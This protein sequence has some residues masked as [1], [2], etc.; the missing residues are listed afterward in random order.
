MTVTDRSRP[1]SRATRG[2]EKRSGCA[3]TSPRLDPDGPVPLV[4][5]GEDCACQEVA[6]AALRS[7]GRGCN[8]VFTSFSLVSLAA[9][10]EAGFG[11]MVMPRG[12]RAAERLNRLEGRAAAAAARTLLRDIHSRGRQPRRDRGA[13]RRPHGRPVSGA[14]RRRTEEDDGCDKPICRRTEGVAEFS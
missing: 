9:A 6:V 7:A 1:S 13:R 12:S 3:A 2:C 14:V 5:Y 11:V 10:V 4:C 8:F